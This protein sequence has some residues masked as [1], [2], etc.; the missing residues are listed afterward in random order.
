[1]VALAVSWP[2]L[3]S[4]SLLSMYQDAQHLTLFEEAARIAVARFHELPLWDPYYCGGIPALGTPSARFA[5]PTFLLTLAFGT[6]RGASL[7]SFAMTILGME[8]AFRYARARGAGTFPATTAAPLFAL[9]GLFAHATLVSWTNFFGFELVPWVLWGTRLA[10]RDNR[11]GLVLAALSMAFI[12]GF[13]GTYTA[14][15]TALAVGFEVASKVVADVRRSQPVSRTLAHACIALALVALSLAVS[16]VRLWPVA[17]NLAASPRLLGGKPGLELGAV[18]HALFGDVGNR[19]SKGDLLVGLP[20]LPLAVLGALRRRSLSLVI[21]IALCVWLA[22]GYHAELSLF[23]ALRTIPPYTML[24]APERFLLFVALSIAT[25]AAIGTRRLEVRG[26]GRT[27]AMIVVATLGHALLL[28]DTVLLIKLGQVRAAGRVL[29]PEPPKVD[30]DFRQARGNRWLAAYYP[31]M[32]RGSLTCFD[33]YDIAQSPDLRGDLPAEEYL[34]DAEAGTVRRVAWSPNH[35]A[36]ETVLTHP[37]RVYVNQNW[38]PGWRSSAGTVVSDNGLLAVDLPAGTQTVTLRFLP[39]SAL[40]GLATTLLGLGAAGMLL[41]RARRRTKADT[42]RERAVTVALS[43]APLV[44][45]PLS[46]LLTREPPRPSAPLLTPLGEPMIAERLPPKATREEV[47]WGS[48]IALAGASLEVDG[49]TPRHGP[50]LHMELDWRFDEPVPA[51]LGVFV[52]FERQGGTFATDHVLL[53]GILLPEDAPLHVVV[54][55][56][57]D[58]ISLPAVE[59]PATWRVYVGVWRARRDM[60]RLPIV[61]AGSSDAVVSADRVLVG[62]VDVTR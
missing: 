44:G 22:C 59:G 29:E 55:D 49:A 32:S 41:C 19:W 28:A 40:G 14:P 61:A 52:Q 39:R 50:L 31:M 3:G 48:G 6:L 51:G 37:A 47:R 23:A 10:L 26:L 54:R 13:G 25:L 38:H 36:L 58:A 21:S 35:V 8:G 46:F 30:R 11:R 24:R 17:E 34:R 2:A 16:M 1:M 4:A 15:L 9:S 62:S 18:L 27:R 56:V 43:I 12:V 7:A 53:S 20:A 42:P 45:V 57:S 60:A 33:D 5:A